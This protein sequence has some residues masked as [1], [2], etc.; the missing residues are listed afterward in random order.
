MMYVSLLQATVTPK[1][2]FLATNYM[3]TNGTPKCAY[4]AS[5][6]ASYEV[7]LHKT[8][9][10]SK[11]GSAQPGRQAVNVAPK[12]SA[13]FL[14]ANQSEGWLS[15]PQRSLVVKTEPCQNQ[16]EELYSLNDLARHLKPSPLT[17]CFPDDKH[18]EPLNHRNGD[19]G[20]HGKKQEIKR[21]CHCD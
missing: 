2:S 5:K 21:P 9:V 19:L 16:D 3:E 10:C 17:Q 6:C 7:T 14:T 8:E 18:D 4:I 13:L 1:K 20:K 15:Q 12:V 11:T